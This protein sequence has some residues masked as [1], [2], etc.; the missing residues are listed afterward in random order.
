MEAGAFSI[1]AFTV[2]L[3][4]SRPKIWGVRIH[5]STAAV[6]GA[7]L[8]LLTGIL[9]F[10]LAIAALK[11]LFFPV[12]TIISLMIITGIA[13][14]EGLFEILA[15]YIA[16]AARGDGR[17]LF[18][19]LFFTG[20]LTGTIFTNDAA[21]LIFTPLVFGLI[22][23]V[24][25]RSWTN[26]NKIPY[27]FAV[28]YI[29]NLVGALV[30]SNPINIIVSNF[31][32]IPFLEYA[33]WMVLPAM[34]SIVVTYIGLRFYF[35]K[36]IPETFFPN[37]ESPVVKRNFRSMIPSAIVLALTLVGLFTESQTG[38]PTWLV[39]VIGASLLL[40]LHTIREHSDPVQIIK[41]VGWDVIVFVVGIFLI[42]RGL[43]QTGLTRQIGEVI[44]AFA[45]HSLFQLTGVTSFVAAFCSS[46]M[47]NHP[48][49]DTMAMVIRDMDLPTLETRMLV[50]SSLIGGD[51]GPK[52]LPIGSLAALLWFRILRN[53][54]V[55]VKYSLYI[56]IGIPVTLLAIL[57]SI[58]TLNA[59]YLIHHWLTGR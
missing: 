53:K 28:L 11:F 42:A 6:I 49:A 30:I 35:R 47:N 40:G 25:G 27:Y 54:G 26:Q 33:S 51:L 23:D 2:T 50:F 13:E 19:F 52:M 31:F 16:K 45:G 18:A 17:K 44:A 20:A 7:F 41:H 4:L 57:L 1:L 36:D 5:H 32:H 38:I 15:N 37:T 48:T 39:A 46:I 55:H 12:I 9:P 8:I 14:Q 10:G 43:R 24:Q 29:A 3:S 58:L 21:V 34:V 59:E 56:K 22:E